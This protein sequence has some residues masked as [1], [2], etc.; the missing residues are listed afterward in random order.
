MT[1]IAFLSLNGTC[2]YFHI[3]GVESI[4]RRLSDAL[5]DAGERISLI[6]YGTEQDG[7]SDVRFG[8]SHVSFRTLEGAL[9][10]IRSNHDHVV[11]IYLRPEDRIRYARF[12]R[13]ASTHIRF[14][15]LYTIWH[16]QRL[17]RGFVFA[18]ARLV[19]FNGCLFCISPRMHRQ[20]AAW[21]RQTVVLLP[22]VPPDYFCEPRDKADAE[23]LRITYAGRLDPA[24]GAM[25]AM[26]VFRHFQSREDTETCVCGYAWDHDA[27]TLEVREALIADADAKREIADQRRWSPNADRILRDIL[28]RTDILLLPYQRLSSTVDMPLLLLE[29]MANLCGIITP[30]LGSLH[31]IYGPSS[32]NLPGEWDKDRVIH[33]IESARSGLDG[34][35]CRLRERT[36]ALQFTPAD[37]AHVFRKAICA[38]E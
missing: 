26:E 7:R 28:R 24:K 36:L 25:A 22:P 10:E 21:A 20:V 30:A 9:D 12:R 13:K 38:A 8:V 4:V 31:E 2:D 15:H 1:R 3:G 27:K 18:E 23:R 11:S 6:Q 35:R 14:H 17:R 37:I 34:E 19:P 32:L 16:E 29:G 33:L 5:A